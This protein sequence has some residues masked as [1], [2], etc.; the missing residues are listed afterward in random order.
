MKR[1]I[2][3]YY[4]QL[5]IGGAEKSLIRLMNTFVANGDDVTYLGRYGGGKG[6]YLLDEK[7][8]Q[9][10]LSKQPLQTGKSIKSISHNLVCLIQRWLTLVTLCLS[11]RKYDMAFVGLQGLSPEVV[12]RYC[13]PKRIAVFIR[14]DISKLKDN[15]RV[16]QKLSVHEKEVDYYICV[17]DSVRNSL[18]KELPRVTKKA[19]VVYNLLNLEDM[20]RNLQEAPNPFVDE[21]DSTFRILTVCRISDVSK[22]VLRM[23]R[24]CRR[25]VDEGYHFRWYIVGDGPDLPELRQAIAANHLENV[26]KTPGRENNPFGYYRDCDLVAMLSYYEGLCG[27]VNE[28]KIS[29]KAIIATVVS[30]VKEQLEHGI[31]GWVVEND[32]KHIMDGMRH[33][34]SNKDVVKRLTN[35]IY[36]EAILNDQTKLEQ[37]YKLIDGNVPKHL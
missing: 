3:I 17:A 35:S 31:N 27:V 12:K 4:S 11:N 19:V 5:N 1:I 22:G 26:M 9:I 21:N 28:A 15:S 33:L 23:V 37:L 24:I 14:N 20:K 6:E 10:Y 34:L 16:L 7:V 8:R 29:G 32:E 13:Q 36:P 25:L 30:G 18:I 2:L